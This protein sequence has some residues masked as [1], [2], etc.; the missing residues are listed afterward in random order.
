M[1]ELFDVL[2]VGELNI[3][4][5]LN[6]IEGYPEKGKEVIANSM[7]LTLGSSSAIMASNL[8]TLGTRVSF[9]GKIG[10]DHFGALVMSALQR[11]EIDTR[12]INQCPQLQTGATMALNFI[13][14]RAMVTY[15]GS[16]TELSVDD[17]P[18]EAILS[19]RHLHVSSVFLQPK[20]K[21]GLIHL[22]QK[23]KAAGLT[24]SIDPQWD[25]AGQWDLDLDPLLRYVDIFLPNAAEIKA[26][27]RTATLEEAIASLQH[28]DTI[29]V[30]K[31]GN[32]GALLS[33]RGKIQH[34]PPFLNRA[35]VDSIGAGDSFNAGFLHYFILDKPTKKCLE[36][37][38]LAGAINTTG[39]GG[40]GAFQTLEE[41]KTIAQTKFNYAY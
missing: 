3:D 39:A 36:F 4:L 18:E 29:I 13:E 37:A 14:E 35:V 16:M 1:R 27:T 12:F 41:V 32:Q 31:N 9:L 21:P 19:A 40:T 34:Q 28:L 38:A 15:P 33:Q 8:Q 5:I 7:T 22:F 26:L 2:V 30:V 11:K 17:I 20:L 24:T 23:A 6:N 10:A 25:P